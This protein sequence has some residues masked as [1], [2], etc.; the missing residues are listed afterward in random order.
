MTQTEKNNHKGTKSTKLVE[1]MVT[2]CHHFLCVFVPLWFVY[3]LRRLAMKVFSGS[4]VLFALVSMPA[5][6][7]PD[8]DPK[9]TTDSLVL[10]KTDTFDAAAEARVVAPLVDAETVAVVRVDFS[11]VAVEPIAALA[12]LILPED[13]GELSKFSREALRRLDAFRRAGG[14][15]LYCVVSLGGEG[16]IPSVLIMLP[17]GPH[18]D[19]KALCEALGVRASSG[20]RL[21]DLF[22]IRVTPFTPL[23]TA[24][25]PAERP[26]LAAALAAAGDAPVWAVLMPPA[27]A[28]RA[29]EELVPQLPKEIGSGPSTIL[30]HGIVWAAA[31]LDL[32]PQAALHLVVQSQDAQ[33]AGMLH[34]KWLAAL[35]LGRDAAGN[36]AANRQLLPRIEKVAALLA[37][38]IESDRLTLTFDEKDHAISELLTLLSVP[39]QRAREAARRQQSMNNLKGIGLAMANYHGVSNRFPAPA[40]YDGSGKPL[41]SW[42]VHVLPYLAGEQLYRQF[43][44]DEPWDSPHNKALIEKMPAMFRSPKSKAAAGLTNYLVPVG[45]GALYSSMK[46][47]PTFKDVTKGTSQTI[48]TIE[49]DDAHAVVWTRPAD[50]PFDPADPKKGFSAGYEAG[51]PVGMCDG[52]ARILPKTIDAKDLKALMSRAAGAASRA[53]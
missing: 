31:R 41:L 52:S 32:A 33:A 19:E 48:M 49:V 6:A 34:A 28:R 11:R 46:D 5:L 8:A 45:G 24:L 18:A 42:R 4:M 13:E 36:D 50:L 27:S 14:K 22:V 38:K 37:P 3:S 25:H 20:R 23:P 1:A 15:D 17:V 53:P 12:G 35:K 7:Q 16:P 39:V 30:T 29:I 47:Q 44:L 40:S 51:Y 21:G 43:H 9:D 2:H 10:L 26:E